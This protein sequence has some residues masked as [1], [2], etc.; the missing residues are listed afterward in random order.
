V[1]NHTMVAEIA[2][3]WDLLHSPQCI[4]ERRAAVNAVATTRQLDELYRRALGVAT[5]SYCN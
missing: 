1:L 5:R 4:A 2:S 3:H